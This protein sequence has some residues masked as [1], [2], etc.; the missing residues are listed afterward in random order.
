M[1]LKVTSKRQVTF[2]KHVMDSLRIRRGDTLRLVETQSG[3]LLKSGRFDPG[4]LAPLRGKFS[5]D[6]PAPDLG[7][8]RHAAHDPKLRD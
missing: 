8:I 3:L 6:L 4:K 2:P 7:A 5:P 1:L